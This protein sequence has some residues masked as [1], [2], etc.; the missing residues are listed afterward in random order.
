[1]TQIS[2]KATE[3]HHPRP[4][5]HPHDPSRKRWFI[6]SVTVTSVVA[7]VSWLYF[8]SG[9]LN[10]LAAHIPG[11][12]ASDALKNLT[13]QTKSFGTTAVDDFKTTLAPAAAAAVADVQAKLEVQAKLAGVV[14]ELTAKLSEDSTATAEVPESN[15]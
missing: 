5:A 2:H 11:A 10:N 7:V 6:V 14:D 12:V 4:M 1:M 9:Q 15:Q 8:F 13:N 3:V